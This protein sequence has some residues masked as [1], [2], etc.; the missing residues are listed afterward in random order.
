MRRHELSALFSYEYLHVW[1]VTTGCVR[2]S[3]CSGADVDMCRLPAHTVHSFRLMYQSQQLLHCFML[4]FIQT[5]SRS[6]RPPW[7][8][9]VADNAAGCRDPD[10][11]A[12]GREPARRCAAA[13][14]AAVREPAPR[15][16]QPPRHEGAYAAHEL[17]LVCPRNRYGDCL[18]WWSFTTLLSSEKATCTCEMCFMLTQQLLGFRPFALQTFDSVPLFR[19]ALRASFSRAPLCGHSRATLT[20]ALCTTRS[21]RVGR[22]ERKRVNK[23]STG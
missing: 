2:H 16:H 17:L 13:E 6:A 22:S 7:F 15:H 9:F 23:S 4:C 1:G 5:S 18:L 21:C 20:A 12:D 11:D 14:A 8:H 3:P 19:T 10:P